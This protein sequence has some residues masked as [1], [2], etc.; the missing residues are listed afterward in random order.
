MYDLKLL[1]AVEKLPVFSLA[2]AAKI[3][4]S[5]SYA[6][7]LL[8][9]LTKQSIIT[10]IRRDAYTIHDDPLVV[11]PFLY[12]SYVSCASALQ[13]HG[14]ISQIPNAIFLMT[15]KRSKTVQYNILLVYHT[16]KNYFGFEIVNYNGIRLPM[17]SPEKAFID[18]IGIHPIHVILE[19]L[20]ELDPEK[21]IFYAKR[22][23]ETRRVGYLLEK[24][25]KTKPPKCMSNRYI[26][27][28]PLG[29]RTGRREKTWKLILN[30]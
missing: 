26:Y 21:I 23:G 8:S 12:P 25:C 28:D 5:R 22:T 30:C 9:R 16:T 19:A 3:T 20:D 27:L 2:D 24:K 13:Y 14:L 1:K 7:K 17:A 10:R 11:A 15:P 18:S 6:K 29:A 4:K